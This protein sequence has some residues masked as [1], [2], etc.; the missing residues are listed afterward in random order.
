[1]SGEDLLQLL[2]DAEDV[3]YIGES[4]SQLA[5]ALQCA[6]LAAERDGSDAL[7]AASLLH[8]IGH[9]CAAAD[10]PTMA[11]LGVLDHETIGGDAAR[12][13]GLGEDVASLITSH[14]AAKR[15]LVARSDS[16][17]RKL[18]PASQGTLEFQGGPMSPD[19]VRR[20]EADPLAESILRLRAWDEE[21]KNPEIT[22]PSLE[23]YRGVLQ[24][25]ASV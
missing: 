17:R 6:A 15:Y 16:Y 19:E 20:F 5:H 21:A 11:G 22:V 8:D 9:L 7:V 25:L 14:V 1:M 12:S 4:V 18:S 10:A 3:G 2:A 13:A 23:S 24:R